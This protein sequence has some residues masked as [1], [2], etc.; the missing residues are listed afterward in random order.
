MS[1]IPLNEKERLEALKSY[2]IIDT[3]QEDEFNR[4]T[5]LASI[6][7]GTPISLITLLDENRQ[8]FKSSVGLDIS[9][10]PRDISFCQHTILNDELFEVE[11]ARID[12]RFKDNELVTS[13]PYI[14][15]YAGYPIIDKNGFALGSLCVISSDAGKLTESQRRAMQ[16]LAEETITLIEER[17]E[18]EELKYFSSLFN[19]SNDLICIAT[20][21][22]TLKKLNPAFRRLLG[23][24]GSHIPN[25][26]FFDAVHPDDLE[27]TLKKFRLLTSGKT[28]INFIHRYK[29]HEGTYRTIQWTATPEAATDNIFAIARDITTEKN[30][31][32]QL[33]ISENN[34]RSFFENSQGLMCT[35]DMDG[36][37]ITVNAAGAALLGYTVQEVLNMNLHDLIPE[38]NHPLL[39]AYLKEIV[40]TGK[41]KGM[42]TTVHKDGTWRFWMYNNI[43]SENQNGESYVIGNSIDV[44]DKYLLEKTLEHTQNMLE[45]TNLVAKI[46]GWEWDLETNEVNWSAMTKA[47]HELDPLHVPTIEEG[48]AYYADS[49][50]LE[51]INNAIQRARND[52]FSWDLELQINTAKGNKVWV[53][54]LGNPVFKNGV[55]KSI[56]G[57]FQDIDD[58][59]KVE[60]TLQWAKEQ[61]E[62]ANVAKSEFL[63]NMSHEIRT[64]LN[65]VIGF[66][67][68]VL[69][70]ELNAIQMQYLTIV[71][72][73]ANA[74]LSIINDI[75]DFSKIEAGKLE[76]DVEKCDVYEIAGQAADIITYQA[77]SKGLEMLLNIPSDL[78][79]FI[80]ADDIRLK[81][82]LIN[83]LGNA[84]KFTNVGEI[85]LKVEVLSQLE[86]NKALF[87]FQVRDSGIGIKLEKQQKI[88]EAF[89][90][91]DGSTTKKYGGTGL[92]LTISNKLLELMESKLE[93]TS[94]S[95][96]GSIFYF[97]VA[98]ACEQGDPVKWNNLELIK[99][100]LVVDDNRNNRTI[101]RQMLL[102]KNIQV[103]EAENGYDALKLLEKGS[104]YDVILMDYHMPYMDGLETIE[105]VRKSFFATQEEQPIILL[106]SSSD[107][108]AV[109][110]N[111]E[112][113]KVNHRLVKPIKMQD[114]YQVLSRLHQENQVVRKPP[115]VEN[116]ANDTCVK[117][118]LIAEDNEINMFL[119]RTIIKRIAPNTVINEVRNGQECLD[120]CKSNTPDLILMDLQMPEMNGYEATMFIRTIDALKQVPI[121]AFTAGNVKGEKEKC[122]EA[123]MN[124]FIS[125]PVVEDDLNNILSK[126]L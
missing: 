52:G 87:R 78:P 97:D 58:K 23:W 20:K 14:R 79:R 3:L 102:L 56:F 104:H 95:G 24:Q 55:C 113:L 96:T 98:L 2:E 71:N 5:E 69:K 90:Q 41:S 21:D 112:R 114:M 10:T 50:S 35:H 60:L 93:L 22:G 106:Y 103:T 105:K 43:V 4:I 94:E 109:I 110:K 76:L 59:K 117:S 108:E 75:L 33:Q 99:N 11:D 15:F 13:K 49:Y 72:Q 82:V 6:I 86:D 7:C 30:Q 126:W 62:L 31:E 12:E 73:S 80:W 51:Q 27:N 34:L 91:E 26:S 45:E 66:T 39:K 100:V 47:I 32:E 37:F 8:W 68:L 36:N 84:V 111:C 101:I 38:S 122:L 118:I 9:E 63:A 81:Q 65:G 53:R 40:V 120:F 125:K 116:L 16:L 28:I 25:I 61:A 67:D 54:T 70:T 42:M 48:L 85:E 74:L 1:L 88:F 77:Q 83:L 29:S 121:I 46:G 92:G 89:S 119:A 124:D 57:T 123:G 107:D 17:R 19:L 64:P 18:K 44:T 115:V